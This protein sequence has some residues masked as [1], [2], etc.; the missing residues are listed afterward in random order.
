LK[1]PAVADELRAM[2]VRPQGGTPQ[3][4]RA[5]LERE[6]AY[7]GQVTSGTKIAHV[8]PA[9]AGGSRT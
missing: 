1:L 9:G 5:L 6:I 4:M 2:G 7:A 8:Q 3:Q